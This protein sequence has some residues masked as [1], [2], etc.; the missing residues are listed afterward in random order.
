MMF[1]SGS[2]VPSEPGE[3]YPGE[4]GCNEEEVKAKKRIENSSGYC[5]KEVDRLLTEALKTVDAKK[6]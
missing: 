5:N 6:R 2:E 4:F 1:L 3:E